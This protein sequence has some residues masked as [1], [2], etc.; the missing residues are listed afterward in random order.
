MFLYECPSAEHIN[1][2]QLFHSASLSL[3]P[4]HCHN[5]SFLSVSM[6]NCVDLTL[7][8]YSKMTN[9]SRWQLGSSSSSSPSLLGH[10][11]VTVTPQVSLPAVWSFTLTEMRESWVFMA[12]WWQT[13]GGLSQRRGWE[14]PHSWR[15]WSF[16]SEKVKE[17]VRGK[18][19]S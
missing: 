16:T 17:W 6:S 11:V 12:S 7:W 13:G 3:N 18:T 19:S 8:C 2:T 1:V 15:E 5:H 4:H 10:C 9:I 14:R